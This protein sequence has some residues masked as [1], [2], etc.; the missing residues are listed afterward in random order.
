MNIALRK[1]TGT[2]LADV[3]VQNEDA[4]RSLISGIDG[5]KAYYL[6]RNDDGTAT[7]ISIFDDQNGVEE[8]NRQAAEWVR[9]NAPNAAGQSSVS[10][11]EVILSF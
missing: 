1:Y 5:F 7:S 9:E 8:S 10:T 6:L 2:E 3:L 11:G 4:V